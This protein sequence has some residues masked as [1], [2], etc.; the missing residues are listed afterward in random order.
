MNIDPIVLGRLFGVIYRSEHSMKKLFNRLLTEANGDP[1]VAAQLFIGRD[2]VL[3]AGEYH[4]SKLPDLESF[5]RERLG[6]RRY[7]LA[8]N[9][10]IL[11]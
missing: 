6:N 5:M 2:W 4:K 1:L 8:V 7:E 10:R 9:W 11:S 3:T